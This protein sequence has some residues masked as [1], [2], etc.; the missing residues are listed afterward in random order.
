MHFKKR[1]SEF[2]ILCLAA[3]IFSGQF[4][5][6][7]IDSKAAFTNL[8][9]V[10]MIPISP[11]TFLRGNSNVVSAELKGPSHLPAGDW[12][13]QPV[14]EVK[15]SREFFIAE[16]EV[17][18]EQFREF[19][20]QFKSLGDTFVSGV[21]WDDAT[22]FCR[23]L[24]KREGK[25]Y[26]LP[27]EAEWEFACRAGSRT[28][29]SSGDRPPGGD[30][31]NPWG[32]KNM[33]SHLA[34]WCLDWHG[35]YEPG[36]QTDPVGPRQ[37]IARAVRGGGLHEPHYNG[38][39]PFDGFDPY[40]RRSANRSSLL[41][42]HRGHKRIGFRIVQAELPNTKLHT[43]SVPFV[44][45]CVKQ[46]NRHVTNGPSS[47][48][49]YFRKRWLL[50]IPPENCPPE[51]CLAAGLHPAILSH[52][53]S[54]ALEVMPN[55]DLLAV[56]FTASSHTE[57][58]YWPNVALLATRLR[59]G[60]DEWDMPE[61]LFDFADVSEQAQLLWNDNGMVHLFWGGLDLDDVAF[62]W[63]SSHDNGATWNDIQFVKLGTGAGPLTPQ[64]I[65]SAFRASGTMFV[66]TDG[67]GGTSL[68]MASRDNGK[69]WVDTGGRTGGRHTTFVPLKDGSILGLGGKT[70]SIDGYMP[71]SISKD[72][73]KSWEVTKSPFVALAS[74]Q[75][76][77]LIRLASGRLFMA[78]DFQ[79]W[80]GVQPKEIK[81]RGSYVALSDDEGKTWHLKTLAAAMPH[82]WR[83]LPDRPGTLGYAVA[84]QGPN[85]VIHLITSM[86]EQALHFE[87]N[88][89]W[90]LAVGD[91]APVPVPEKSIYARHRERYSGGSVKADYGA[92]INSGGTY[93]LDG[94]EKWF[95]PNGKKQYEVTYVAGKKTGRETFWRE[96]GRKVW[97]REHR[98]NG[99]ATWTQWWPNGKRKSESSWHEG[100][101]EGVAR[102][103]NFAREKLI[104]EFRFER[105][106]LVEPATKVLQKP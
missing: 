77:T 60:A 90:I 34:E 68:L 55:G 95:Y 2:S 100:R 48:H 29:F 45:Q 57:A 15:I 43:A 88:E 16:V 46:N 87:M 69:S 44:Q 51:A 78:G 86:N 63:C 62:R 30:Q 12:D 91:A 11:G 98:E 96:D 61:L 25:T 67:I 83:H 56:Y 81:Q 4:L 28:H 80:D 58:E 89:A 73:G 1:W 33:H 27:T 82:E 6:A 66:P 14:H 5:N 32:V 42:S 36:R 10:K 9:G 65:N 103:W 54:P 39:S 64:P 97:S 84:R 13:E 71:Q 99:M 74:N 94:T 17:T 72:G 40:W 79:N 93:T 52:N 101:C 21:S 24:T 59:F 7:G 19:D 70:T 105:G 41:P 85:G 20:P 3:V 92:R 102:H 38:I 104:H 22:A 37:G 53:H 47:H 75:R 49:P 8:I 50:P 18:V 31:A 35:L 26:R 23:W 106:K 76:P